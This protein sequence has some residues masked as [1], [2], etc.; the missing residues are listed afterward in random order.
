MLRPLLPLAALCACYSPE[1]FDED[2]D[3]AFCEKVFECEEADALPFLPYGDVAE[4]QTFRAEQREQNGGTAQN[5]ECAYDAGVAKQCVE[6]LNTLACP[7]YTAG[8][9]PSSCVAVCGEA[10]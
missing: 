5:E 3:L 6:D 9:F 10:S 4:C 7:S 8:S 1:T 2:Y